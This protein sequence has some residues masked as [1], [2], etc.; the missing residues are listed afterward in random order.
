MPYES[1]GRA[2]KRGN[3]YEARWMIHQ[4]LGVL[5]EKYDY[6]I[7]EPLGDD[8]KGTDILVGHKDGHKEFQQCKGRNASKEHWD[9]RTAN[10]R[11]IFSAWKYQ[12]DRD[13]SNVVTLVSPLPFLMLEDLIDRA[14]NTSNNP[15]DFYNYQISAG[16]SELVDFFHKY[17]SVMNLDPNNE[18]ELIKCISYLRRTSCDQAGD[19]KREEFILD[20]ISYLFIGDKEAIYEAFLGWVHDG[21]ILGKTIDLIEVSAFLNEKNIRFKSL[22]NDN[23]IKPRLDELNQEYLDGFTPFDGGLIRRKEFSKFKEAVDSGFSLI[24]H[25]KAGRGKSGY[26]QDIIK[27]CQ[28][29]DILYLAIK[30]D[31]RPPSRNAESW[32][33]EDLGL[34]ASIAHCVHSVSKQRKAIIVLDQLDALRWTQAHSRDALLVCAQLINQVKILNQ[35]REQN[36]ILIFVCRTYDLENDNSIKALFNLNSR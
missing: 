13:R 9:F 25:G 22:A 1:G 10:A 20:K 36:I 31:K 17:C 24:V 21:N 7:L 12:L 11:G 32:S 14:K 34:P 26:T 18:D 30:L 6:V 2:S 23:R 16:S 5:E 19:A 3:R 33:K 4:L 28:E 27:Y 8:E 29:N 35:E 15:V